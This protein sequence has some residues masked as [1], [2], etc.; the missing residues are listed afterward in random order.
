MKTYN[1]LKVYLLICCILIALI[2]CEKDDAKA[3]SELRYFR[4]SGCPEENH[5]NWQDTSFVAATT[6]KDVIKKC[7]E[8]LKL[9]VN[10]R[11]LFPLG[12]LA[13]GSA[14]Y[15][16]NNTHSFSWH[17]IEDD[18]DMVEVGIEIYDG[19]PYSDAEL[20]DYLNTVERYGGW[21]NRVVEELD[22]E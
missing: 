10:E 1:K 14:G 5:G 2:S 13:S 7:L 19:C 3:T 9:P 15:N 11:S 21:G 4:F 22:I 16:K 8:Q 12:K 17:L 6:N 18:W 20:S